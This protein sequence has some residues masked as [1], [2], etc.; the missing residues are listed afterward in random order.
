MSAFAAFYAANLAFRGGGAKLDP[1]FGECLSCAAK[2][3]YHEVEK[4]KEVKKKGNQGIF[5][6]GK[7]SEKRGKSG[8]RYAGTCS[9]N[10]IFRKE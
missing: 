3:I 2:R 8:A 9:L 10:Q 7:N 6:P 4:V 5:G 1:Q